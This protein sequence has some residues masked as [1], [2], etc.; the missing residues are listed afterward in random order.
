VSVVVKS[1]VINVGLTVSELCAPEDQLSD[2]TRE[3]QRVATTAL[4]ET[5]LNIVNELALKPEV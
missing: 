2:Q 1:L 4:D 3:D 5:K